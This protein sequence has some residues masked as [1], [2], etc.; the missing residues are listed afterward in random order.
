MTTL[1][2]YGIPEGNL[3]SIQAIY[4]K[5][6]I[7]LLWFSSP[8]APLYDMLGH[9]DK[10]LCIDWSNPKVMVSGSSDNTLKVFKSS[11]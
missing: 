3:L 6:G 8:K 10:V 5:H 9:K 7:N 4:L 2:N 1:L 11:L